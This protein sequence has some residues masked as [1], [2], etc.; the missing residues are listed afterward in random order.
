MNEEQVTYVSDELDKGLSEDQVRQALTAAGYQPDLINQLFA[1]VE[2]RKNPS[3][4]PPAGSDVP[5]AGSTV[6]PA[7]AQTSANQTTGAAPGAQTGSSQTPGATTAA[8]PV[9][10]TSNAKVFAIIGYVLPFLF[11]L[12]LVMDDLKQNPFS[13]YHA[14]QSLSRYQ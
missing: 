3:S 8:Q 13:R 6:P 7:G 10:D 4:V 5:P 12:P 14:N 1:E 11:F 9:G 2:R